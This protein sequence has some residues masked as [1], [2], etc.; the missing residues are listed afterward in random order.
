MSLDSYY[1]SLPLSIPNSIFSQNFQNISGIKKYNLRKSEVGDEEV[2]ETAAKET[3]ELDRKDDAIVV[4][5]I[6]MVTMDIG[7]VAMVT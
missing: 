3:G 1:V 6:V 5:Y 4:M 2:S 7:L